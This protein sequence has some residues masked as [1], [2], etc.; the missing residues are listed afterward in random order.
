M[1]FITGWT[2]YK[3]I[4]LI[5]IPVQYFKVYTSIE[6]YMNPTTILNEADQPLLLEKA[7]NYSS[8][9]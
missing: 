4:V 5:H 3:Y 9:I 6:D 1:I 8:N 7:I 2:V